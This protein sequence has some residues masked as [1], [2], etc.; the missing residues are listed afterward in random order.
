[1][2]LNYNVDSILSITNGNVSVDAQVQD[3]TD[4]TA[5]DAAFFFAGNFLSGDYI[6]PTGDGADIEEVRSNLV[7]DQTAL[8]ASYAFMVDK[9][10]LAGTG[11]RT[12]YGTAAAGTLS[13]LRVTGSTYDQVNGADGETDLGAAHAIAPS[14]FT[15][16]GA[17]P[18]AHLVPMINMDKTI[19][20]AGVGINKGDTDIGAALVQLVTSALFKKYGKNVAINNETNLA[21][22][23]KT[24]FYTAVSGEIDEDQK[25]Y[26]QSKYFKRYLASGRHA[27]DDAQLSGGVQAYTTNDTVINMIINVSGHVSDSDSPESPLMNEDN[28]GTIFGTIAGV[29]AAANGAHRILANGQYETHCFVSLKHDS[30]L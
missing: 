19:P 18:Q 29:G 5:Y 3:A 4:Q 28:I 22:T 13:G 25:T 8:A 20:G 21:S 10:T 7:V 23:L 14:V 6:Q 15:A 9:A 17:T 27:A 30:R 11:G 16:T 1:M 24:A 12:D 2:S 26:A